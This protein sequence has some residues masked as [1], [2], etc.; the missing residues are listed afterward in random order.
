MSYTVPTFAQ[1]EEFLVSLFKVYFA[2]RNVGSRRAYHRYKLRVLS[3]SITELHDHQTSA[4]DDV[5]PDSA[6]GAYATRWGGIVGTTRKGATAARKTD[7]LRVR[8][9]VAATADEGETLTHPESGQQF[10]L[11]EDVVIPAA[12]FID[13]DVVAVSTGSATRLE[14]GEVLS[15]DAT[16]AGIETDAELQLDVD[17]DGFDAEQDG[18]FKRRYLAVFAEPQ[19]GG[20]QSDYVRW[21][22]Q[23][24]GITAA[25][26]YPNR[27]GIGSVDVVAFHTGSGSDR[28]LDADERDALLLYLQDELA[29]SQVGGTG[30]PLR[31][32]ETL[33]DEQDVE[34]LITIDDEWDWDDSVAPIVD[35]V[36][37]AARSI[38]FTLDRPGSMK[39]GD[40]IVIK[41]IASAQDGAPLVIESL[42]ST[43]TIIL[44][45]WPD[46]DPVATDIVYAG[47]P[48]TATV[49]DAIIAH[50]NGE[51]VYA[52]QEGPLP[53]S[54]AAEQ[55]TSTVGLNILA[56]GIGPANVDREFGAWSGSLVR[57][58]LHKLATY[59]RGVANADVTT[60]AADYDAED[61]AFPD[62]EQI[63]FITPGSV[64]VRGA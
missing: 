18:A 21:A 19:A 27:A 22:L 24:E 53:E 44:E 26:C 57:A 35:S 41:G 13:V 45:E 11:G 63:N 14:A 5:M 58:V 62:D 55:G 34:V 37:S 16:P 12:G 8:G 10:A 31:V 33:D 54:V 30:G 25:F 61:P 17:D 49:R 7:A 59:T 47:G 56:E 51:I 28:S 52:D 39:A 6:E 1:S 23:V 60:P 42:S 32:L 9:T 20:N 29:P 4:Q 36:D 15:F 3:A 38:T 48:Q 46:V 2:D 50:M 43:D 40:R 64:L